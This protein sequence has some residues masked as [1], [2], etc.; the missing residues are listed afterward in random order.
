MPV[1]KEFR[2]LCSTLT[3]T[4]TPPPPPPPFPFSTFSV[5]CRLARPIQA[6]L[7]FEGY[8]YLFTLGCHD[9]NDPQVILRNRAISFISAKP[10]DLAGLPRPER[11]AGDPPFTAHCATFHLSETV[12]FQFRRRCFES[13]FRAFGLVP[14]SYLLG[15]ARGDMRRRERLALV[16]IHQQP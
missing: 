6:A 10:C 14:S 13:S 2:T 9:P 7:Y 3:T 4:H 5:R 1:Y 16:Q 8:S 12:R 15:S 11:P